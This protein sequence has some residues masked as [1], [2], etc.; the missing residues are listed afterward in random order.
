MGPPG[1]G[2]GTQGEILE[3]RYGVPRFATGDILRAARREGTELGRRAQSF[4]DAGELVP[5]E[6]ILGIIGEALA[7]ERASKGFI[8]DG[9]PRTVAQAEGLAAMLDDF[10]LQLDAVLNISVTDDE[11]VRRLSGRKVCSECGLV[12]DADAAPGSP[13]GNCGGKLI[14]RRDDDED[15]VRRRL[16]V[17]REQTEP[18]LAWFRAIG[19]RVVDVNGLGDVDGITERVVSGI[20]A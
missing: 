2:K 19:P 15:T 11:I 6:V 16:E 10:G 9:F 12:A 13:C 18:V 20:E 5:D 3:R 14:Q 17:Y 4:M 1:A 8:L 7:G